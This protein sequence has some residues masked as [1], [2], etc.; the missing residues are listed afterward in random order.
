[1]VI[2]VSACQGMVDSCVR[3]TSM[4]VPQIPASMASAEMGSTDTFVSAMQAIRALIVI[5]ILMT[6]YL[7]KFPFLRHC[8]LKEVV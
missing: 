8:I 5:R 7:G 2:P 3:L 4:N 1:M 6:V